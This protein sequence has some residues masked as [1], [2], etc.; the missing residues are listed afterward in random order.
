MVE[1]SNREEGNRCLVIARSALAA[2]DYSKAQRFA[3]KA[4]RLHPG[5]AAQ[6]GA[7][8]TMHSG[9]APAIQRHVVTSVCSP[10][11]ADPPQRY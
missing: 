6:V 11:G 5:L 1:A 8:G 3:D 10:A 9:A 7:M 2:G 4:A